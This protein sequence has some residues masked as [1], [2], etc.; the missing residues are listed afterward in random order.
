MSKSK[1]DT[2]TL[3]VLEEQGYDPINFR[4]LC[5]GSHYRSQLKFSF[6]A[7]DAARNACETLR[8]KL[9]DWAACPAGDALEAG[10]SVAVAH[11]DRFWAALRDDLDTP[12]ALS[13]LWGA[14]RDERL[15]DAA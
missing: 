9:A 10:R 6:E 11:A 4:Y 12:V 5:L 2:L 13:A 7:L 8:N 15:S 3:R 14:L 1:G